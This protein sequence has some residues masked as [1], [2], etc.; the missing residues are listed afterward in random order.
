MN[1]GIAVQ[2]QRRF[3]QKKK[4]SCL[5]FPMIEEKVRGRTRK[6]RERKV[7]KM[8]LSA[9]YPGTFQQKKMLRVELHK[10]ATTLFQQFVKKEKKKG[11]GKG[12]DTIN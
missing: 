9:T 3:V 10:R 11:G 6:E 7:G 5:Y 4:I 1:L 2:E 12:Q 8:R